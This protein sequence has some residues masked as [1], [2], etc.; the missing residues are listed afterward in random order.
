MPSIE[1]LVVYT[2][3]RDY[4]INIETVSKL[5]MISQTGCENRKYHCASLYM[6]AGM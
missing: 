5:F 2:D 6:K 1:V 3:Y 4:S